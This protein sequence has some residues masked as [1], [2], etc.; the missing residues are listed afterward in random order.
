MN[1]SFARDLVD[2]LNTKI[3]EAEEV[4]S[5]RAKMGVPK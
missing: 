5:E 4:L 3:A 2:L 1:T